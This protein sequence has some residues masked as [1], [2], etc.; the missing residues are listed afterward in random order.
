MLMF[1]TYDTIKR[2]DFLTDSEELQFFKEKQRKTNQYK[3][4][5][6][7]NAYD[8]IS[9]LIPKGEKQELQEQAT[10]KGYKSINAY[11]QHLIKQD[12]N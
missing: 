4:D 8:R 10:K 5:F 6:Q 11:I 9:L 3:N 12:K 7:K 1:H 2:G